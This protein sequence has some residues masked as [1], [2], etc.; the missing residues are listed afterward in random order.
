MKVL[1]R[2][3]HC[4]S[5]HTALRYPMWWPKMLV[6]VVLSFSSCQGVI[7]QI[8]KHPKRKE[9]KEQLDYQLD[10]RTLLSAETINGYYIPKD[11]MD[12][13][14]QLDSLL[15]DKQI[16]GIQSLPNRRD[17]EQYDMSVGLWI[18]NHWGLWEGSRLSQYLSF[19]KLTAPTLQSN[20]IL[21]YYYDYLHGDF[22]LRFQRDVLKTAYLTRSDTLLQV[23]LETWSKAYKPDTTTSDE[24]V[25]EAYKVFYAFYNPIELENRKG[26]RRCYNDSQY[27]VVC[28][29]LSWLG[30]VDTMPIPE[31]CNESEFVEHRPPDNWLGNY[32]YKNSVMWDSNMVFFAPISHPK[33]L[34]LT[35]EYEEIL[36]EFL[37]Q[38]DEVEQSRRANFLKRHLG[39]YKLS[40]W[41]YNKYKYKT[42]PDVSSITF[43][44]DR[45]RAYIRFSCLYQ[46]Y[47]GYAYMEKLDG[48]WTVVRLEGDVD[49]D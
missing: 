12:C 3:Y 42:E 34:Y 37:P 11:F 29:K 47:A 49:L 9:L 17:V 24:Y 10:L 25:A 18:R 39:I 8:T 43:D 26:Y 14:R 33:C 1:K 38:D 4:E 45:N 5:R 28:P 48:K 27:F 46:N 16:R 40:Y 31:Y 6:L 23:F 15:T 13:F 36:D 2:L 35:D 41:K 19:Y 20:A 7:G 44:F 21:Q 32:Y 22:E 30:I